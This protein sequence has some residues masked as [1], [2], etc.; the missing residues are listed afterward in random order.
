MKLTPNRAIRIF[1]SVDDDIIAR[2]IVFDPILDPLG[3]SDAVFPTTLIRVCE[4][5]DDS[6][7]CIGTTAIDG[8]ACNVAEIA[9]VIHIIANLVCFVR[10]RQFGSSIAIIIAAGADD[11]GTAQFGAVGFGKRLGDAFLNGCASA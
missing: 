1:G 4:P 8:D 3:A 11:F 7:I 9:N 10:Y 2:R 6:S 5:Q